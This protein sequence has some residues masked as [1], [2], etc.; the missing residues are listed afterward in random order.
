LL[1]VFQTCYGSYSPFLFD[2]VYDNSVTDQEIGIGDGMTR[3]FFLLRSLG[4]FAQRV[5][6]LNGTPTIKL[7]GVIQTA[8]FSVSPV[9]I[10]SLGSPPAPGQ[11]ITWSGFYRWICRF[12]EDQID[13]AQFMP[14]FWEAK[15]VKFSTE[16]I[17]G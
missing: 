13:L 4:G 16:I 1:T 14:N 8:T 2:D 15:S 17:T 10:I 6:A 3:D 7:N 9:G 11:L 12:D 5:A